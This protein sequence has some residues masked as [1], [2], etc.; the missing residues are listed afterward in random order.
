MA[1]TNADLAKALG[2]LAAATAVLAEGQAE[3]NRLLRAMVA[4]KTTAKPSSKAAE[5]V[6]EV[7]TTKWSRVG[8]AYGK[9]K[10]TFLPNGVG[11]SQ[12][13]SCRQGRA[14]LKAAKAAR[15][16]A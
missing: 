16:A 15:K 14:A 4:P 3:T 8:C 11:S 10:A 5:P 9:C 12:H 7:E 13:T 2:Q 1:V 6:I